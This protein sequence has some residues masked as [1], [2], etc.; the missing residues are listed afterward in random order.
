MEPLYIKTNIKRVFFFIDEGT[1]STYN[2]TSLKMFKLPED[3]T[4]I[5][6]PRVTTEIGKSIF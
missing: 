6:I 3:F 2:P 4:E 1:I 5:K